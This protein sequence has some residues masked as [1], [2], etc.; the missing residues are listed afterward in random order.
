MRPDMR[1]GRSRVPRR[2]NAST[3]CCKITVVCGH[4]VTVVEEGL[5]ACRIDTS[6]V[7]SAVRSAR[8]PQRRHARDGGALDG[9]SV[10]GDFVCD[11]LQSAV[12]AF[13][14]CR[15]LA[16]KLGCG[17]PRAACAAM[18]TGIGGTRVAALTARTARDQPQDEREY[19]PPWRAH[20][21]VPIGG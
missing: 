8:P 6:A 10:D 15:A 1:H 18:V 5:V 12:G 3:I 7:R 11:L 4:C 13:E 14:G 19:Q 21:A 17:C 16:R 9:G 2:A 20:D